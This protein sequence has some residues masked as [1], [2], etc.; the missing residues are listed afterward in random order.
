MSFDLGTT[1]TDLL[2]H[3]SCFPIWPSDSL[4]AARA[5][6]IIAAAVAFLDTQNKKGQTEVTWEKCEEQKI[7]QKQREILIGLEG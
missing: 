3:L 7:N 6:L 2:S 1:V 4:A 5:A